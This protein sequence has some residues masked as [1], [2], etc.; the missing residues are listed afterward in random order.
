MRQRDGRGQVYQAPPLHGRMLRGPLAPLARGYLLSC[1]NP[2]P[3]I[4]ANHQHCP[5]PVSSFRASPVLG[6]VIVHISISRPWLAPQI[7]LPV[8]RCDEARIEAAMVSQSNLDQ[9]KQKQTKHSIIVWVFRYPW[10]SNRG[11][12][13]A[14]T[15]YTQGGISCN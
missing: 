7:L 15:L 5:V 8:S 9:R 12:V 1:T 4:C 6:D 11:N 3:S 13:F 2:Q 14:N 10:F